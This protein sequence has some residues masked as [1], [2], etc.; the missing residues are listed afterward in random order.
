MLQIETL[1]FRQM[2]GTIQHGARGGLI[3]FDVFVECCNILMMGS[4]RYSL[5]QLKEGCDELLARIPAALDNMELNG[6]IKAFLML[7]M[8]QARSIREGTD[9][10]NQ[11]R[12]F[13][14]GWLC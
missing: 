9:R 2:V 6:N 7:R 4:A 11:A 10:V 13:D 8:R 1:N 5:R 14:L 3:D 12:V